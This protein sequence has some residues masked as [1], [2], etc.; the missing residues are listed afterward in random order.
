MTVAGLLMIAGA[1][2]VAVGIENPR[3]AEPADEAQLAP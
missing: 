2:I 1:I 3:R